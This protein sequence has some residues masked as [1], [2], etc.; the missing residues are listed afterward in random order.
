MRRWVT[1]AVMLAVLSAAAAPL[2]ASGRADLVQ[3]VFTVEGMHCDGCSTAIVGAL[4]RF[5]GVVEASADHEKGEAVAVYRPRKA[6][7]EDLKQAIEKLG[8][9]VTAM[10]SA[11]AEE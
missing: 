11:A 8:Y 3:T 9:T 6:S 10:E 2:I 5:D 7:A 4:K 1:V